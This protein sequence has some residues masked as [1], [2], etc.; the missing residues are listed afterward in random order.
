MRAEVVAVGTELLLGQ[1]VDTNSSWIGEQ[2]ALAGIDVH[3]QSKVGDNHARMV[4]VL[5]VALDRNDAVIVCGGLGPTQDDIT[6]EALAELMGVDL[7]TDAVVVERIQAMFGSRGRDMPANNLR[8]AEVPEGATVIT[9]QPGTAPGLVCPVGDKV[10]YAVPGVPYEMQEMVSGTIIGDLRARA[11]DTACIR[12]RTLRTWGQSESG[13]AE[14]LADRID[15]LDR[16]GAATIAFLASGIEGLKVRITAKGATD[17]EVDAVL[18]AE[19]HV[20]RRMLGEIVFGADDE[21]M[22]SVVL[23]LLR[24]RRLTLAVA[25]S[26]TGGLIAS[27]LTDIA[28]ASDVFRGGVVSYASD[29]KFDVLGVPEGPVVSSSAAEAMAVGVCRVL[30]ADVGLAVTGVAGPDE[31]EGQPVGT[32]HLGLAVGGDVSSLQLRLPGDRPRIRQFATI[33]LLDLLRRRLLET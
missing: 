5:Q 10:V 15:E 18:A 9:Q 6:R 26:V 31:Q 14:L 4:D 20:L 30:G 1:I 3:Y 29:V 23:D 11:G 16:S 8:Q 27:R 2:L 19:E 24:D 28:G 12:S 7:V 33:T 17:A 32:V 13:L 21:T 25:E 22:E